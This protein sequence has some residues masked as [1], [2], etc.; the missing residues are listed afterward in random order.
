[1]YKML[2]VDDDS[3]VRAN[4]STLIDWTQ[5]GISL[6]HGAE[7]GKVA[8]STILNQR[9]DILLMDV[10]MPIMNGIELLKILKQKEIKPV[11]IMISAYEDYSLVRKAFKLGVEDY[12]LKSNIRES[13]CNEMAQKIIKKLDE[14]AIIPETE[15]VNEDSIIY[16]KFKS[17]VASSISKTDSSTDDIEMNDLPCITSMIILDDKLDVNN[18]FS[19]DFKQTLELPIKQIIDQI[20]QLR[21]HYQLIK[22]NEFTYFLFYYNESK[23]SYEFFY[24]IMHKIH[25]KL[26]NFMN[27]STSN[28]ISNKSDTKEELIANIKDLH[29]KKSAF[30]LYNKDTSIG[31][32]DLNLPET[33]DIEP[34]EKM[35]GVGR[36]DDSELEFYINRV[37]IE[38]KNY[39]LDDTK[40]YFISI[41]YCILKTALILQSDIRTC[42]FNEKRDDLVS[43]V[44][45]LENYWQL[46]YYLKGIVKKVIQITNSNKMQKTLSFEDKVMNFIEEHYDNSSLT[47]SSIAEHFNLNEKYFAT[48]FKKQTGITVYSYLTKIRMKEAHKI[49]Q[50]S[51]LKVYEVATKVGFYSVNSFS[52]TYKKYFN[53]PPKQGNKN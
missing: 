26:M 36:Y 51:N 2:I 46:S 34:I 41:V 42:I 23:I 40:N 19:K 11:I 39:S 47:L 9:V 16:Q 17:L 29:N 10:K 45:R 24:K 22:V 32:D 5:Y 31:Q 44:K 43:E 7:N 3:M 33:V 1:M 15:S 27:L 18:R 49:L 53:H 21:Y 52:R 35:I 12:I 25:D 20:P 8:L 13:E 6:L 4:L 50:E 30:L 38:I 14:K 37:L 28:I 48:L